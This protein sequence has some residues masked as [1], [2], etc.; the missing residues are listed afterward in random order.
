MADLEE[1]IA[2]VLEMI[3]RTPAKA[4]CRKVIG[5][6]GPP[7]SGKSTLAAALVERLNAMRPGQAVLVPMDGFHM[8]NEELD[9]KGLRAVK[10]APQTFDV[11]GFIAILKKLRPIGATG[12]FPIFDRS[13]DR[14]IPDAHHVDSAV[15]ILVVEGNYLLLAQEPWREVR[16]LLDA[17]AALTPPLATLE[18][19]LMTRWLSYGLPHEEAQAKTHRNDLP[20]A[21][22]VLE[23]SAPA[24]LTLSQTPRRA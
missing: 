14:T 21:R 12:D 1:D 20:N 22:L 11:A 24:T 19:R 4:G 3:A 10:G 5:I 2:A 8:D 6:L 16:A 13:Q 18:E 7:G 23:Q 17:S 9:H 15:E